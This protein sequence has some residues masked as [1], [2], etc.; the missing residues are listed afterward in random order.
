MNNLLALLQLNKLSVSE[1][2]LSVSLSVTLGILKNHRYLLCFCVLTLILLKQNCFLNVVMSQSLVD[3]EFRILHSLVLRMGNTWF[4]IIC[5]YNIIFYRIYS[6]N[7]RGK[8]TT[9]FQILS[10]PLSIKVESSR[11]TETLRKYILKHLERPVGGAC[12][13]Y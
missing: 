9:C 3:P 8:G 1:L 12:R 5:D 13:T 2:S 7:F 11:K 6:D 10:S 4:F